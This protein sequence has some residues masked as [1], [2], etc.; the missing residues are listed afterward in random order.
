MTPVEPALHDG[1]HLVVFAKDQPQYTPLPASVDANGV[2][3]T[4]WEPTAEELNRLL[5]GGRIRMWL[6]HAISVDSCPKCHADVPRL[7]NPMS[8]EVI[9]PECGMGENHHARPS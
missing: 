3:M 5:C 7:L 9:E 8:I 1:A 4:E 6:H 2:V